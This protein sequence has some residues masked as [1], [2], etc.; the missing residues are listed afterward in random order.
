MHY[1]LHKEQRLPTDDLQCLRHKSL[2]EE[3]Q[4]F[5]EVPYQNGGMS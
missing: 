4:T 1:Y 3:N 2:K 5:G